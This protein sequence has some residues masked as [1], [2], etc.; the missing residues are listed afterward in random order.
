MDSASAITEAVWASLRKLAGPTP[1]SRCK[2]GCV[3]C[4]RTASSLPIRWPRA[5]GTAVGNRHP[6]SPRKPRF[7]AAAACV[8]HLSRSAF[9]SPR[10]KDRRVPPHIIQAD[11]AT[12]KGR[13]LANHA[14][15]NFLPVAGDRTWRQHL[16]REFK[17]E[18][19]RLDSCVQ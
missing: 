19:T 12:L 2:S 18:D 11:Q 1:C 3:N 8:E 6:A 9:G 16:R 14:D 7:V 17:A 4:S 5:L 13:V 15:F 10:T